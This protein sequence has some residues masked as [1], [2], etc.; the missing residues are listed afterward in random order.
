MNRFSSPSISKGSMVE[1][2][3]EESSRRILLLTRY[4]GLYVYL[5]L[6]FLN[7]LRFVYTQGSLVEGQISERRDITLVFLSTWLSVSSLNSLCVF[8][9]RSSLVKRSLEVS[10]SRFLFVTSPDTRTNLISSALVSKISYYLGLSS[11]LNST[12][13]GQVHF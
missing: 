9:T 11:F 2:P 6:C 10:L 4:F 3:N 13:L 12:S 1:G 7:S 5:Q 8:Y